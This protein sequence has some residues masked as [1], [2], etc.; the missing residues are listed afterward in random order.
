[1]SEVELN[2][3]RSA[4]VYVAGTIDPAAQNQQEL[5][6][7]FVDGAPVRLFHRPSDVPNHA[8]Y[9]TAA[10]AQTVTINEAARA[11]FAMTKIHKDMAQSL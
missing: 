1:M 11:D 10:A 3:L 7:V 6:D 4:G 5:Y 2:D 8:C 9:A